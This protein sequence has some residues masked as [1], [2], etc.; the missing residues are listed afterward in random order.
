MRLIVLAGLP[1]TGKSSLAR[2]LGALLQCPVFDK[3]RVRA[4]S[5]AP[6]FVEYSTEQDD[7][8]VEAILTLIAGEARAGKRRFAILDGRCFA[9]RGQT[10]RIEE[11]AR[12]ER[13]ELRW[14]LMSCDAALARR[15]L[16]SEGALHPAAD[17]GADLHARLQREAVPFG[18]LH[19]ALSSDPRPPLSDAQVLDEAVERALAWVMA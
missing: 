13:I 18:P 3:D 19:L 16:E 8:C 4:A 14:I 5:Y 9:R 1:G 10:Q 7:R 15:R 11:F 2:R 17:R 6:E 12:E